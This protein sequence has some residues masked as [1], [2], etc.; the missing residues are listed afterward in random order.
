MIDDSQSPKTAVANNNWFGS[1]VDNYTAELQTFNETHNMWQGISNV[2]LDNWYFLDLKETAKSNG[3]DILISLN[4]LYDNATAK[5]TKVTDCDLPDYNATL[6]V[7]AGK[8]TPSIATLKNGVA[9]VKYALNGSQGPGT[10]AADLSGITVSKKLEGVKLGTAITVSPLRKNTYNKAVDAKSNYYI[11]ATLK[12]SKGNIL[13]GKTVKVVSKGKTYTRTTD[14]KGR[15]KLLVAYAA[16]GTYKQT[17]TF[18]GDNDYK[19]STN[20]VYLKVIAQKVKLTAPKKTFKAN[21]KTKK[22]TATLKNS[23]GKALKGKKIAFT[24][25]GKKYTAKTN[26]KGVAAVKVSLSK[27]KT[28]KVTVK[29]VGDKTYNKLTKTS[30]VVIK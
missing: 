4:N 13:K 3:Y 25:N 27:K 28:Y 29:F 15:V 23:K 14:S 2:K 7:T 12:D 26:A 11:Y 24:V 22:L 19:K 8:V 6:S 10:I 5:V 21:A 18:L 20:V 30:S 17:F 16:K 1:T 9:T